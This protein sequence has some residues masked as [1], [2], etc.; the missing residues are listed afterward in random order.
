M[1]VGMDLLPLPT[2]RVVPVAVGPGAAGLAA[3]L[4]EQLPELERQPTVA[5]VV[6]GAHPTMLAMQGSLMAVVAAVA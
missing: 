6:P 2:V 4:L 3:M 1:L 5:Q